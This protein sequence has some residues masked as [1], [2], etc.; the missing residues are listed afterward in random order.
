MIIAA[1]DIG[2]SRVVIFVIVTLEERLLTFVI[3]S[4]CFPLNFFKTPYDLQLFRFLNYY[5]KLLIVSVNLTLMV[6]HVICVKMA[7][8][9]YKKI[10]KMVA[11]NVSALVK[12]TNVKAPLFT[13]LKYDV[14][15]LYLNYNKF[16]KIN[17]IKYFR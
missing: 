6:K 16:L 14:I 5:R 3:R 13:N 10:T 11:Q 1:L 4:V 8:L 12:L 9:T 17:Y 7:H 2:L 15:K